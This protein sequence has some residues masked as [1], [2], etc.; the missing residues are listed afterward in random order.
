MV[1]MYVAA[2]N[3]A[4]AFLRVDAVN[5]L[6]FE[7]QLADYGGMFCAVSLVAVALCKGRWGHGD[8]ALAAQRIIMT[9]LLGCGTGNAN[10][11]AT[12][13]AATAI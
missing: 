8:D 13:D 3:N 7:A 1:P 12:A 2:M 4:D 6:H 9:L 11:G 5:V 10:D